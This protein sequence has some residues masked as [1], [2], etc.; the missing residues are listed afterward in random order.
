M[1]RD[2]ADL[3]GRR[4]SRHGIRQQNGCEHRLPPIPEAG[5]GSRP[6]KC[7]DRATRA[8]PRLDRN[9]GVES[10]EAA[11]EA[12]RVIHERAT[13]TSGEGAA[14][15]IVEEMVEA[16]GG[17]VHVASSAGDGTTFT[18]TLPRRASRSPALEPSGARP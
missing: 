15:F 5:D 11:H 17:H 18:V 4:N 6:T 7:I 16:H 14:L 3:N 8:V 1:G 10:W 12:R 9:R 13:A 2:V